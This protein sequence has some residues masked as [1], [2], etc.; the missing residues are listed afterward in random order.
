MK[1]FLT[2]VRKQLENRTDSEHNQAFLRLVIVL[3]GM[4]YGSYV[5][6]TWW[7]IGLSL[8]IT[9]GIIAHIIYDPT[10]NPSR[11]IVGAIQDNILTTF[12]LYLS[13]PSAALYLFVYPF[14]TVGNGFRFGVRY[15]AFSGALGAACMAYLI[16]LS[17]S[18]NADPMVG[19]GIL[20]SNITVTIYTG[21][22]L[23]KLRQVQQK[24][25]KMAT[26]D[27]LTGLPNR[28]LFL[29]SLGRT[30]QSRLT[31]QHGVTCIYF[32]LDGFKAV[33]DKFGH[34]SGDHLLEVV[35]AKVKAALRASDLVA[36][37]GGDEFTVLLDTTTEMSD[38]QKVA[39][40]I[41]QAIESIQMVDGHPV[42]VSASVGIA[43]LPAGVRDE[44]IAAADILKLADEQMYSAKRK[45]KGRTELAVYQP[46]MSVPNAA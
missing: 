12:F 32:D 37:L 28:S 6:L 11:R 3:I 17:P 9:S 45:G 36:R 7:P 2:Y 34:K 46:A 22:L 15:L 25:T 24:I 41:I 43:Y 38:A 8:F 21:I 35:A 19:I 20:V 29:E 27:A 14:I 16:F 18:W 10:A 4:F 13:G 40:R 5:G 23:N 39:T 33:N 1:S 42:R 44:P 31:K 30:I 26:H